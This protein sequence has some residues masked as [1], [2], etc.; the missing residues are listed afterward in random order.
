MVLT[1]VRRASVTAHALKSILVS[2]VRRIVEED[3]T[4]VIETIVCFEELPYRVERDD[5][6]LRDRITV[7]A[8]ANGWKGNRLDTVL[9]CKP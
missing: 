6:G 1:S 4:H 9:H 7:H 8:G 5:R 2:A 3:E